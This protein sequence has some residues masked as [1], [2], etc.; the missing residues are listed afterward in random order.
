MARCFWAIV[1]IAAGA[2]FCMQM[3]EVLQRYFSYPKK[4]DK[5]VNIVGIAGSALIFNKSTKMLKETFLHVVS[6]QDL[7]TK[8]SQFLPGVQE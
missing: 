1:C 6:F 3:T 2:M 7:K 4:V 5:Q 8:Q